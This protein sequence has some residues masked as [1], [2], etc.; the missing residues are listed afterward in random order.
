MGNLLRK[1]KIH[2][3]RSRELTKEDATAAAEKISPI[4][5]Y[6]EKIDLR[7][8]VVFPASNSLNLPKKEKSPPKTVAPIRLHKVFLR[9]IISALTAMA[10]CCV[11]AVLIGFYILWQY[12]RDLPD[13]CFL[14]NYQPAS[15]TKIYDRFG[16][17][18]KEYA[19]ERREYVPLA[20]IP[21]R[22]VRAFIA[23]EDKNFYRHFG[24]DPISFCKAVLINTLKGS[25]QGTPI[26]ASTITQQVAKI[27][28]VGNERSLARKIKEAILAFRL[29]NT[30]GKDR[31]LELYLNQIYLGA[32]SY[33]VAIAAQSYFD[34]PLEQLSIAEC[35]LLASMPKAPSQQDPFKNPTRAI[36]RRNWVLR[37]MMDTQI[38][39][40]PE[41]AIASKE[42]LIIYKVPV[43]K[44]FDNSYFLEEARRELIRH[45]GEK[46]TY[47][48]GLD[49]TT[50]LHPAIQLTIDEALRKCLEK[51]D[52]RHGWRGPIGHLNGEWADQL[53]KFAPP[54]DI[55]A[56]AAIILGVSQMG[57]TAGL[58]DKK[59]IVLHPSALLDDALQ[60]HKLKTGD[61]VLVR[62][63]KNK[64]GK[65]Q[66]FQIPR[67]TGGAVALDAETGDVL[68][69]A[70]GYS[71][72][73]S[74]FNC[75][76][77]AWR[78]PASTFKPFVYLTALERG[79]SIHSTL[80]ERPI[81]FSLSSGG[82]YTP[83]NYNRESYGG[84]M[85]LY[86]GLTRSR[87][88]FTV[89]LADRV[90]VRNV[91]KV[92]QKMG[93]ADYFPN[94]IG[95]ALGTI[96][97]TPMR[98]AAA[99]SPFF[100]GGFHVDPH[101]LKEVKS[102]LGLEEPLSSLSEPKR[103]IQKKHAE[104]MRTMLSG[105]ITEGTGRPLA[106]LM[107]QYP[108]RLYGKTGTSSDFKDAWFVCGIVP[109]KNN[110]NPL[111][112]KPMVFAVFVGFST[113]KSL[114]T[115]ESGSKVALPAA[116]YFIQSLY[117]NAHVQD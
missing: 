7:V 51:Y 8:P 44:K 27:F 57:V 24:I 52:Q 94:E 100:N 43:Y 32:S 14:K 90:G 106:P 108:I 85:S 77:Q 56:E 82:S 37:R 86:T 18:I 92:A 78:Q 34:K 88:V 9:G 66:L 59:H 110:T 5:A 87:N 58:A 103:V 98:M 79:F 48:S 63:P 54:S 55:P 39:S 109:T 72:Q 102:R 115:H 23:A 70:G 20:E 64:E 114:G 65:Y 22:L 104:G 49:T 62:K 21:S 19:E 16:K 107:E 67:V 91:A 36:Q 68:G 117:K 80:V 116:K 81:S 95:I 6:N 105:V 50:T 31:I 1:T 89:M 25:W 33:G 60:R 101:V 111:L 30:L 93:V 11:A 3:S 113:P 84:L 75:A 12:G 15:I 28:L 42:P 46:S 45:Y 40:E 112:K 97:T 13:Y 53:K 29:E 76:T 2:L 38:I 83:H 96:E 35:A 26:G 61:V 99:F 47:R 4:K 10:L 73:C 17:Q 69:L 41:Y 71:F 74:Q